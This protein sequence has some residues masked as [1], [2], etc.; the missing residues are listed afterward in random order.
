MQKLI[1]HNQLQ[2]Q[3]SPLAMIE[4]NLDFTVRLWNP[5]AEEIFGF[6][7]IEILGRKGE[8][9][10]VESARKQ[11]NKLWSS[12]IKESKITRQPFQVSMKV[13]NNF[14]NTSINQNI[15]KD[16][17]LIICEWNNT[18]L[19][20]EAG[21]LYGVSSIVEDI[22]EREAA[23]A[24]IEEQHQLALSLVNSSTQSIFVLNPQHEVI[25][26]NDACATLT[27]LPAIKV[28]GTR[29]HWQGFYKEARPCPSDFIIDSSLDITKYY[30]AVK[31]SKLITGELSS[32]AWL[33]NLKD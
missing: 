10:V 7:A 16:G 22:T 31:I 30:G 11:L 3:R 17:E 32:E 18:L 4:W 15:R 24:L 29:N 5:A 8:F 6:S 21:Q 2:F 14:G 1:S 9:L 12:L 27:Q 19:S 20:D 33:N 13:H 23:R 28:L 25:V 26:W